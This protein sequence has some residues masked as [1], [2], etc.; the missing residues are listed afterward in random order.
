M[1]R[2]LSWLGEETGP[3]LISPRDGAGERT[4][5]VTFQWRD[6]ADAI[7]YRIQIDT[8]DTFDSPDLFD[9]FVADTQH[10]VSLVTLGTRYWRVLARDVDLN[11]SPW[12][13][14]RR[15]A[16][17]EDIVQVASEQGNY[18]SPD[19]VPLSGDSLMM[20][21]TECCWTIYSKASNDGGATWSA[22]SFIAQDGVEP[23]AIQD[24]NGVIWLVYN[25]Y[26]SSPNYND[27]FYRTSNDN[28]QTWSQEQPLAVSPL[29]EFSPS[30][31]RTDSGRLIVAYSAYGTQ[32][33]GTYTDRLYYKTSDD[34]G[35]TWS[36]PVAL[37]ES[38]G[39]DSDLAVTSQ[40]VIWVVY[41]GC[42][43]C[44]VRYRTSADNGDSWSPETL[45][46]SN[47]SRPA[48]AFSGEELMIAYTRRNCSPITCSDDIWYKVATP[49]N[50]LDSP[51]VRYTAYRYGDWYPS[52]AAVGDGNFG[53]AW[54]S[55]RRFAGGIWTTPYTIWF[56]IPGVMED[57]SPPPVVGNFYHLP[58]PNP[59]P[60]DEVFIVAGI[61]DDEPGLTADVEW[62]KDGVQQA[63]VPMADNGSSGDSQAGDSVFGASLGV[64]P[65]GT[66]VNYQIRTEDADGNVIE[67]SERS[68]QVVP[69]WVQRNRILLVVDAFY[70]WQRDESAPY[71]RAALDDL[72]L[73]YD[74]WDTSI[75]GTPDTDDLA[76]YQDGA[77]V[78]SA[79]SRDSYLWHYLNVE[80]ATSA[81]SSYLDNGGDLFISGEQLRD[82]Q[83]PA[84][85]FYS[86]YFH[87]DGDDCCV[88]VY[89]VTG[90]TGDAIG[91]GLSFRIQGGDGANNQGNHHVIFPRAPS[92]PVF[93]YVDIQGAALSSPS[94]LQ[95][96]TPQDRD[97]GQ[98][99]LEQ[100][101]DVSGQTS[102][103]GPD[104]GPLD[105]IRSGTAALRVDTQ[106]YRLVYFAFGFEAIDSF[107]MRQDVMA[108]VLNWLGEETGPVLIS[109]SDWSRVDT[110]DVT[111]QWRAVA[112]A[113]DY[114]IQID[115][116][117]TFDSLSLIDTIVPDTKHTVNLVTTGTRYW[118][119]LSR[120]IDLNESPWSAVRRFVI[121]EGGNIVQVTPEQDYYYYPALVPMSGDSLMVFYAT[122]C[123]SIYSKA[124]DDGG[125]TWSE[126]RLIVQD[127]GPPDAIR[128]PD[129]VIW[130]VYSRNS[131]IFYRTT[132]S[133][134]QAWSQ[135]QPIAV[136]P[137]SEFSPSI[138][139][140]ASGRLI[141][142][143]GASGSH[144]VLYRTSDDNGATWSEATVLAETWATDP[145]LAMTSQGAI[146]AVYYACQQDCGIHYR[147]SA[148]NGDS[149]SAE[150][151]LDSSGE[152][153]SIASSGEELMIAFHRYRSLPITYAYD[154]WY[155]VG[156]PENIL[157]SPSIRYTAY[158]GRDF[159]PSVAAVADGNFGITWYSDR[160]FADGIWTASN[161][162][163]FGILRVRE[164]LSPPAAVNRFEHTPSPNPD[165]NDEVFIVAQ[166]DDDE[167]GF[168]A[169][170]V[171]TRDGVQ[172]ADVPMADNG[173]GGDLQPS[174]TVYGASLGITPAGTS[175][176]YRV[177]TEDADGNVFETSERSF[178][179]AP[180]WVQQN[181]IL[182][183]VDAYSWQRDE[184]APYYRA[185]LD[186]LGLGYDFWDTS[187]R[188]TPGPDDLALY[189]DG[190]VIWS[191]PSYGSYLWY[192]L[193]ADAATS[194]LSS[195]LDNGG[196]LFISGE[197]IFNLQWTASSF[198]R[199]YLHTNSANWCVNVWDVNGVQ[200]DVIGDG[201]SFRIQGGDGANNQGCHHII[202]PR[203]PATPVF[204]YVDLH[205]AALAPPPPQ[206]PTPLRPL[207]GRFQAE[208]AGLPLPASPRD[209]DLALRMPEQRL[210]ARGQTGELG[211]DAGTLS[212]LGSGTAALRVDTQVYWLVYFGFGFEA[213][214][215]F[216][217]RQDVMA[218]V[219]NWLGEETG[220]VLISP[221]D[222]SRVDTG[223]VT[224]QWRAVADAVDYR[225]QID[226]ADTFDSL[227]L[228]DTIVPDTQHTVN[229]VTTGTR[230]WRALSRDIDLNESPWSAVRRFVIG[231]GGNIVQ[232]TPE[233]G[234]HF[235]PVLL[236]TS[237]DNVLVFYTTYA[238]HGKIYSRASQDGGSTWADPRLVVDVGNSTNA[239]AIRDPDGVIW[240]VY[241]RNSDIFYRMTDGDSQNWS[242]EQLLAVS[243]LTERDPS[244]L[245]TDNGR[246]IVAYRAY[247]N[248]PDGTYTDKLYYKTSDDGGVTWSDPIAMTESWGREPDLAVTSGDAIW[249]VYYACQQ[250]CGIHY[251][252]SIDNGDS[253]SPETLLE[254]D[255]YDPSI[256]S[257]GEELMIA[258]TRRNC[259]PITCGEDIWFRVAT[260]EN[261]HQ[262]PSVRYTAYVG[263]DISPSAAALADGNFAIAWSSDRR[264]ED[265]IWSTPYTIWFGIPGVRE[266]LVPPPVINKKSFYHLPTPN[267]DPN[268][269]V[270]IVAQ[271]DDDQPGFTADVVWTMDG[272][273]Q[274]DVPMADNGSSG[275][276][277]AG[278]SVFGASLGVLPA[279]ANVNYMIR[280]EDAD[281]NV[282]ES[283]ERS[284]QV[285]PAWVQENRILLVVD[286]FDSR[287]RDRSALY[288]RAALD[289]LGLGYDFWDTSVRGTPDPDDLALYQ[290][291]TVV[292]S[293]PGS[294][295]YLSY[296][297]NVEAAMT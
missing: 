76:L 211:H 287:E 171:W 253:W 10:T 40:G 52:A 19:L 155:R 250:G 15:L 180:E 195:Y 225:I 186:A 84:G 282:I 163:W 23:A 280:V 20:F 232:L 135:E 12:S 264:F 188:S 229:L 174:D 289:G 45:L 249:V 274:A 179:V 103:R 288:Y 30:I 4:G 261:I 228:I 154:I 56:G 3:I 243:P 137:L 130:L 159:S 204:S 213:I 201:L 222:W 96:P 124:S 217:M 101:R 158:Q 44:G 64:M 271:I 72:G 206:D 242:G 141:V 230:Y 51:S 117:D 27:I 183:V 54:Y 194:A 168:T 80:A 128:G 145:D 205:G 192:D 33:D 190:A 102:E 133:D 144:R 193:N 95:D 48:V 18:Y 257:S 90:I 8:T 97:L 14:V 93:R 283:S 92:T 156:T 272:V 178:Q 172:Q 131:D 53:I 83:K 292:W 91:D 209:R 31:V 71:Y 262:S 161:T 6:V 233:R 46:E 78:W 142:A 111:F 110:G 239:D 86:N 106:V 88:G 294:S 259:S 49:E 208:G 89:D 109:P 162:I 39:R 2:V 60:N 143:Y 125:A 68:F 269:Q 165:P 112:D 1:A 238:S 198:Y 255:G 132:S 182:L 279:G 295:A 17:A 240:L 247:G 177:R 58:T 43:H 258:F 146:W 215:S 293:V 9:A 290:D 241:E 291:G 66:S 277:Q 173:S 113:N 55:N 181:P 69:Q 273:Q 24:P 152:S 212:H 254:S 157:Q 260:P 244:V 267:P 200:G 126:P 134:G 140:T 248:L 127:G 189:Q 65:A 5:D 169:N 138:V 77:V 121:G 151:L 150:M 256:A 34:G 223:D 119:V 296:Y 265:G 85:A 197:E 114:R 284:F 285:V 13:A 7:D 246:L 278:D 38:W 57:L 235:D 216:A 74:F 245:R 266:D 26:T 237:G 22:P 37:S 63:D 227:T 203:A 75:R 270:F 115:T 94:P 81:L 226:T 32:P 297:L 214:D 42:S 252:T 67:T 16:I 107:A 221:S 185:A 11:E 170:V 148:D 276:S 98:Q 184:S 224:F 147:T 36:G 59:D 129:G 21:Y 29:E 61:D 99:A 207:P 236:P 118:R 123:W 82:L 167:P 268:D 28:G 160:R 231:E 70:S 286:A 187:I 210:D 73:G 136:S 176:N 62:T 50:I 25:R 275:D 139:R 251:L 234:T 281:G 199:D 153:P 87:S 104:A 220:P 100:R 191:I 218:R 202:S 164:D 108:R 35:A 105:H 166:I 196:N 47:G 175:V 122:C 219:L 149:W 263:V 41:Y 120:D 116:A 79:P